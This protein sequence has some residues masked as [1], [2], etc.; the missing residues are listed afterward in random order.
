MSAAALAL[1]RAEPRQSWLGFLRAELAPTPG[2]LNAT[3]RIVVATAI[4]LVTS[5][6]LE[7]PSV[8]LSLFIVIFFSMLTPGAASQNSVAVAIAGIAAVVV[9]TLAVALTLLI[10]R[11]TIDYPPLRL[12][13]MALGF[14]LAMFAFRVFAA[15]PVGFIVAIV[16]LVTQAAVD[17]V[18][19][20][21]AFVR[22]VLWVWVAIAYPA[23]VAVGVNLL[24]LP[25]DPEPLLRREVAARLRAAAQAM[26]AP[27]GSAEAR[28]AA[29]T[30]AA[31]AEQGSAPLLKLLQ[32]R[33]DPRFVARAAARRADSEDP[34][35]AAPRRS[36]GAARGPRG[37][38]LS[39]RTDP[40]RPRGRGDASASPR[41]F[42]PVSGPCRRRR[43]AAETATPA[44]RSRPCSPSLNGS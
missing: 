33:G 22:G 39:R 27:F 1:E 36:G 26:A 40:A 28:D 44:R 37:R 10:A 16:V 23:A 42:R 13:A 8:D 32:P 7:V 34:P 15:P 21:E 43:R 18:P 17:L 24:L 11:F 35:G 4:V 14:F 20:P 2:R 5:M 29:A 9:L 3:I 25:A 31:F 12:A 30:L 41:R 6:A 19:G 38:A